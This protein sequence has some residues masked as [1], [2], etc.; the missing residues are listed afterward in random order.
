MLDYSEAFKNIGYNVKFSKCWINMIGSKF[1]F[2]TEE[3]SIGIGNSGLIHRC[4]LIGYDFRLKDSHIDVIF[5]NTHLEVVDKFGDIR[6]NQIE[7]ILNH[8]DKKYPNKAILI[9][10]DFNTL[11]KADYCEEEWNN[12]VNIDKKRGFETK[13]DVIPILEKKCYVDCFVG[14]KTKPPNVSAWTNRRVDYIYGINVTFTRSNIIQKMEL[15]DH[16]PIYTD[17]LSSND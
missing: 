10:G 5:L 9:A 14:S 12:I 15:S 2:D 3:V 1:E 17:V 6:S 7:K 8:L 11:R 13:E 4:A 16:C